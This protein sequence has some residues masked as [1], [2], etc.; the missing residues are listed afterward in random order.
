MLLD[1]THERHTTLQVLRAAISALSS[2]IGR[3]TEILLHDLERPQQSV[4]AIANGHISGRK[5]GS[6]IL[7]GPEQDK[8]FAAVT[9][10]TG[11]TDGCHPVVI[12][13]YPTMVNGRQL[14]SATVVF[15]D[16]NAVPFASLCINA[17]LSGLSVAQAF[18]EQLQPML[19]PAGE[20]AAEPGDMEVLMAQIIQDSLATLGLGKMNKKA[21]V[22]AVRVMQERGL[23]IVKGG[24]EKAATALGVTRFTIY[25]YLEQLRGDSAAQR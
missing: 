17:D 15:R 24:V 22:E 4:L 16:S 8:G 12:P 6:P 20:P 9:E 2:V 7:G 14:R 18:L 21:K 13:D 3:N 19:Q 11:A 25:N 5:V 1:T 23:F 10:A